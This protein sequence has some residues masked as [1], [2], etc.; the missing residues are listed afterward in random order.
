MTYSEAVKLTDTSNVLFTSHEGFLKLLGCSDKSIKRREGN[1][2]DNERLYDILN[3]HC[4]ETTKY[5]LCDLLYYYDEAS[6]AYLDNDIWGGFERSKKKFCLWL[7]CEVFLPYNDDVDNRIDLTKAEKIE[8]Y[9]IS[10]DPDGTYEKVDICFLLLLAYGI[11]KPLGKK[12]NFAKLDSMAKMKNLLEDFQNLLPVVGVIK[13]NETLDDYASTITQMID[14]NETLCVAELWCI[15]T[16]IASYL[17]RCSSPQAH[18]DAHVIPIGYKMPGIWIDDNDNGN[19]R[20]WIF[21]ENRLMAFCYT[22]NP[23]IENEYI[24]KP[25]EFAFTASEYDETDCDEICMIFTAKGNE[26]I[27]FNADAKASKNHAVITDFKFDYDDNKRISKVTFT[28][29][30]NVHREWMEWRSFT[31]L[32]FDSDRYIHY[33]ILIDE[34]YDKPSRKLLENKAPWL[35]DNFNSLIAVDKLYIYIFDRKTLPDHK[36][37]YHG[38]EHGYTYEPREK[39]DNPDKQSLLTVEISKANPI[40]VLPREIGVDDYNKSFPKV[41]RRKLKEALKLTTDLGNPINQISIYREQRTQTETICFNR[42][43]LR[44][45]LKELLDTNFVRTITSREDLFKLD[46]DKKDK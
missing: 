29:R 42:F 10:D 44:L 30:D 13:G 8:E 16:D 6:E 17:Q 46:K 3:K 21:P 22:Q 5:E 33:R 2:K 11:I 19:S 9:F 45:P 12:N 37:C 41:I 43:S 14:K 23:T 18:A 38:E 25:Y 15:V 36:L 35:T 39:N 4:H 7:F 26:E 1:E 28:P 34:L 20:F 24:L 27:L 40:Y 32:D 31:R